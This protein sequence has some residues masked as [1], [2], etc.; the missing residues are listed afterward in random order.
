MYHL[1]NIK[2]IFFALF[3]YC[4]FQLAAPQTP[5]IADQQYVDALHSVT[6]NFKRRITVL[7]I[8][9]TSAEYTLSL[10]RTTRAICVALLVAGGETAVIEQ[11]K[12]SKQ[13]NISVMAPKNPQNDTFNT[14][15]RCEHFDVVMVQDITKYMTCSCSKLAETLIKLGDYVF[16]EAGSFEMKQEMVR[17]KLSLVA[18]KGE[19][20]L[21][22]S[23]KQKLSLDIAR[24]TQKDRPINPKPK[25][26]IKSS[27]TEKLFYKRASSEP[28]RWV[29]GINLVTFSMLRGVYPEDEHIRKQLTLMEKMCPGHNDLVLGN[30]ILQGD[31]LIPIDFN[32]SRRDADF[33]RCLASAI[34]AFKEGNI[35]HRNPEKWMNDYYDTMP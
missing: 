18:K 27:L 10:A 33:Q 26:T 21:Y 8:S 15:S 6:K 19:N 29:D 25:Y 5:P 7:E 12:N 32:D 34:K 22:L 1:N 14:I 2:Y 13:R 20:E 16:I 23:Y 17:R 4:A 28:T 9:P 11:V 30:I 31:R 3:F 24:Y 35:R